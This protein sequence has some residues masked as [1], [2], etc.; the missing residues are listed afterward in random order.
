[1][2]IQANTIRGGMVIDYEG[3][4]WSV[5]KIQLLQPG[6]GGAFIQVEMRDVVT[7]VKSQARWR[8][9]DVVERLEVREHECQYLYR[10]GDIVTFMDNESFD[11]FNVPAELIGDRTAFLQ[12]NMQVLVDFIEGKPVSV[13]LPQTVTLTVTDA[14]AVVKGQT[15]SS[16]YK[17]GMLENGVKIMLPPFVTAGTRVVVNTEDGSYVERAK[18]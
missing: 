12:D 15:A 5:L 4:Q 17:P 1:M 3:K 14:D 2:K 10:D 6:K 16:S 11:Q 7:G 8:T 13:K 18:D 9:A